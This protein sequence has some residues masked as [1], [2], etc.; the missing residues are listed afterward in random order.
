M[1]GFETTIT[2]RA[3]REAVWQVLADIG[4]ID[5]W[6]PGVRRSFVTTGQA[7]GPGAGRHCDLGGR[8]YL[9]EEVVEWVPGECL[10]M[11]IVDT[12]LPFRSADIRFT[13]EAD[14]GRTRVTVAPLYALRFGLLGRLMDLLFFRRAYRRGM[15]ALLMGL[16]EYVEEG[17]MA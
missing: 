7:D 2:I 4:A 14:G 15:R 16:K 12:N 5:R 1:R 3:S 13:L 10:T 8:G 6:N 9:V 17:Q 11:R